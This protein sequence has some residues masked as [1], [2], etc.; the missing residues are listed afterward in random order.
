MLKLLKHFC[1]LWF[2]FYL[3]NVRTITW[4]TSAFLLEMHE[5]FSDLPWATAYCW[6]L[7][8]WCRLFAE[9]RCQLCGRVFRAP[10]TYRHHLSLHRGET[11]CQLCH[12]VFS[13]KGNLKSHMKAVHG[14]SLKEP[15]RGA[16]G[17]ATS[18]EPR[19]PSSPQMAPAQTSA[20][21]RPSNTTAGDVYRPGNPVLGEVPR[22]DSPALGAGRAWINPA[23]CEPRWSDNSSSAGPRWS[24]S[25]DSAEWRLEYATR[26]FTF[27]SDWVAGVNATNAL[28]R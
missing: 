25:M 10:S 28:M 6:A 1:L 17:T 27:S 13:H 15:R 20:A 11:T 4:L 9:L 14:T 22:L 19:P 18:A 7:M 23:K 8:T 26:M 21:R 3:P 12:K 5:R 2:I 24:A 16:G